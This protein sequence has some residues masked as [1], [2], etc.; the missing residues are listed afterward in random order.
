MFDCRFGPFACFRPPVIGELLITSTLITSIWLQ[1]LLSRVM[2]CTHPYLYTLLQKTS[3]N[4]LSQQ[5]QCRYRCWP[6]PICC[7][8]IDC[9]MNVGGCNW[10]VAANH[11]REVDVS[12]CVLENHFID[13]QDKVIKLWC[14]FWWSRVTE[15]QADRLAFDDQLERSVL[16]D[17]RVSPGSLV[18]D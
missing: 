18:R 10:Q 11:P 9:C 17:R 12:N 15:E 4:Q 13:R 1:C 7:G 5:Q 8:M 6:E 14:Q 3:K 16:T 2:I